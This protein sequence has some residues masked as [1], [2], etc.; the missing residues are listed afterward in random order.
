MYAVTKAEFSI[1]RMPVVCGETTAKQGEAS[2]AR[3]AKS[4]KSLAKRS[5]GEARRKSEARGR[6]YLK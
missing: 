1:E 3:G 2:E 4:L 6:K 5:K